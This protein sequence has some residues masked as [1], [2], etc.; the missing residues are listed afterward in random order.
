MNTPC[1]KGHQSRSGQNAVVSWNMVGLG[2]IPAGASGIRCGWPQSSASLGNLS[3][4]QPPQATIRFSLPALD[5]S[6]SSLSYSAHH[7][8]NHSSSDIPSPAPSSTTWAVSTLC[9]LQP[10]KPHHPPRPSSSSSSCLPP[11]A[12]P[13][14]NPKVTI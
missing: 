2:I 3:P 10:S 5:I 1:W 7:R 8:N 12:L 14:L 6:A 13:Y 4:P 9:H 11:A